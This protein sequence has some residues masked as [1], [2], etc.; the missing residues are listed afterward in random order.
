MHFLKKVYAMYKWGLGQSPRSK[1]FLRIFLFK[2]NNFIGGAAATHAALVPVPV[3][4]YIGVTNL[5]IY[6]LLC[7][8][9]EGRGDLCKAHVSLAVPSYQPT[10]SKY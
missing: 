10:E 6:L 4:S 3:S 9:V 8:T 1:K 7:I 5:L 2:V